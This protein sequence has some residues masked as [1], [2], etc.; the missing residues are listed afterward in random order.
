MDLTLRG[1]KR[2]VDIV[3]EINKRRGSQ[4]IKFIDIGGGFPVNFDDERDDNSSVASWEDYGKNLKL[5]CPELFSGDYKVLTE[6]GRRTN[7]KPGFFV[8]GVEYLYKNHNILLIDS[9]TTKMLEDE[10]SL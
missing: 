2:I 4:Q 5:L 9:D 8:S 7:A 1:I 10:I 6:F 3:L